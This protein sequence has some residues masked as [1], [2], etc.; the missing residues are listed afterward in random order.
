MR[1]TD[2]AGHIL[3]QGSV[4]VG[5]LFVTFIAWIPGH[6]ASWLGAKSQLIGELTFQQ[7]ILP[8]F[9]LLI[10]QTLNC[11]GILDLNASS[12]STSQMCGLA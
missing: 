4:I 5:I 11:Q 8:A 10:N 2:D 7:G 9:R 1:L 6:A 3:L 12:N